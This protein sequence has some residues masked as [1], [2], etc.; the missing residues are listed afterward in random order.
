MFDLMDGMTDRPHPSRTRTNPCLH[1]YTYIYTPKQALPR[2]LADEMLQQVRTTREALRYRRE[3]PWWW[4]QQQG[5]A[6]EG[7]VD[8]GAAEALATITTTTTITPTPGRDQGGLDSVLCLPVLGGADGRTVVGVVA[9]VNAHAPAQPE[10]GQQDG[11]GSG[12]AAAD[13]RALAGLCAQASEALAN[14]TRRPEERVSLGENL[15]ML[16]RHSA[17][18]L[19]EYRPTLAALLG[20]ERAAEAAAAKDGKTKAKA[21]ARAGIRAPI[22]AAVTAAAAAVG[23]VSARAPAA[24]AVVMGT[25]W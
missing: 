20:A 23:P 6:E 17:L 19:R 24:P 13:A 16:A 5:G 25:A 14:L 4:H 9:A 12:F 21:E 15:E 11:S 8:G 3:R 10:H 2:P 1:A 18:P 22:A 7:A